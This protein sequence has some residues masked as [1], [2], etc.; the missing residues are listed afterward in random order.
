MI[1]CFCIMAGAASQVKRIILCCKAQR[2][3]YGVNET[4][5]FIALQKENI[6]RAHYKMF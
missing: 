2:H 1:N 3:I 5:G 6:E 4:P